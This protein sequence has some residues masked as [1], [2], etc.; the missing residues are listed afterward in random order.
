MKYIETKNKFS[1]RKRI[2]D[3]PIVNR[4]VENCIA[5]YIRFAY[6]TSRFDRYGFEALDAC[7]ARNESVI[8][9][10]WHQRLVM[11]GYAFPVH[12]GPILSL[13]TSARAGRLIGQI[14]RRFG[15]DNMAMASKQRH[16]KRSRQILKLI[17]EGA[18]IG[19][20]VDG[21][22]GPARIAKDVPLKWARA[23]NARVFAV[24]F[25]ANRVL[26][27]PTWDRLML[28]IPWSRGVI[29]CREWPE[30]VPRCATDSDIERLRLSLE[31]TI[32][33]VT[34]ETDLAI[35]KFRLK[36]WR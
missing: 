17:G 18:S 29:H 28:P 4:A 30:L 33:A 8:M 20:A 3:N 12:L 14:L 35:K 13:T 19:I 16:I 6:R 34:D 15:L 23:S 5:A 7:V 26:R 2:A 36:M 31:K 9:V 25:S 32:N 1:L 27:M 22:G 11:A 21:P 10:L 24:S